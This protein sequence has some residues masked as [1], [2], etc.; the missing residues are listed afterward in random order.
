MAISDF[1]TL[2]ADVQSFCVRSDSKFGNMMETFVS[3]AEERI[4]SGAGKRG[5]PLFSPPVR[6]PAMVSVSTITTVAAGTAT[7]DNTIIDVA[8]LTVASQVEPL[9]YK[10]PAALKQWNAAGETGEPQFYTVEGRLL[11]IAPA[12]AATLTATIYSRPA[13]LT[14]ENS[15]ST[16]LTAHPQLYLA[17]TLFEAFTWLQNEGAAMA[18]LARYRAIA[19]GVNRGAQ[20]LRLL[21]GQ[22]AIQF[23]AIG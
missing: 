23:E 6:S 5:D 12:Q 17:A 4:F 22:T 19:E 1:P 10:S 13:A 11:T 14:V 18:H 21:S 20:S 15:T 8:G 3:F 7:L 9:R 16:M 2:K